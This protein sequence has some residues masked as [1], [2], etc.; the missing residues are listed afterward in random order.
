MGKR[1]TA[2]KTAFGPM[3]VAACEQW[4][5]EGQ[6]LCEDELAVRFLPGAARAMVKL[7]RWRFVRERLIHAS[8]NGSP[9]VWAGIACRK[10]Y[11]DE[12]VENAVAAGVDAVVVLGAGL[13]TRACRLAAPMNVRAYEVDLPVNIERKRARMRALWGRAPERVTL[14]PV[15]FENDDAGAA[16]AA[17]GFRMEAA[18]MFVWEAV[19]QYLTEEGVR[20]TLTILAKAGAGSRLVFTYVRKDFLNGVNFYGAE[21]LHKRFVASGVWRFGL[22]PEAVGDFLGAYE[23]RE[24]EQAGAQEFAERYVAPTGRK[25]PV[26]EVERCVYAEIQSVPRGIK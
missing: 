26:F 4:L 6:R 16:L 19:S 1:S 2:A 15:D 14:V 23:W 12:K 13:D 10:R 5:P 9:G 18:T 11:I 7:C 8:E 24:R 17:N 25:L 22:A 20:K 3:V 21:G